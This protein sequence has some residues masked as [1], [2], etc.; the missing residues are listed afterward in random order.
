MGRANNLLIYGNSTIIESNIPIINSSNTTIIETN[1]PT[2]NLI[3]STIMIPST[4]LNINTSSIP[5]ILNINTTSISS[6]LIT[7]IPTIYTTLPT[8]NIN[9][10]S[11]IT[12]NN[13][14]IFVLQIQIINKRLKIFIL[15]NYAVSKNDLF[16]FNINIYLVNKGRILQQSEIKEMNFTVSKSNPGNAD[17]I[18]E[19]TS[20]EE[21]NEDTKATLIDSKV[22]NDIEVIFN[23]NENNLD[24][25][26]VK[27]EIKNGGIDYNNLPSDY[28]I[29]HYSIIS[30]TQGCQFDLISEK[31]IE[32]EDKNINLDFIN[33]YENNITAN[34]F[35][36]KSNGKKIPCTFDKEI[37]NVYII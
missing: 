33:L 5:T 29:Y 34:C 13:K 15:V 31:N 35:L 6:T 25:E 8:T 30:S 22:N 20:N 2:S 9:S 19:L 23:N 18:T 1:I 4:S 32:N 28:K 26:N 21:I 27:N 14:I 36:S 7:T 37:N 16:T 11:T 10:N 12:N 24:T 3:K 17:S